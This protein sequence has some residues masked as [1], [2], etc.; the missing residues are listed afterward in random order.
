MENYGAVYNPSFLTFLQKDIGFNEFSLT[1]QKNG[2]KANIKAMRA[3]F[4]QFDKDKNGNV[5]FAEFHTP[6]KNDVEYFN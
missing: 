6:I 2:V 3:V 4:D 5:S 1:L